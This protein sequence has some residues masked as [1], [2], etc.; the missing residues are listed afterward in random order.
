MIKYTEL[1]EINEPMAKEIKEHGWCVFTEC[2]GDG[3]YFRKGY[4]WVNRIGYVVFEEQVDVSDMDE[5]DFHQTGIYDQDFANE[6]MKVAEKYKNTN[7]HYHVKGKLI[8]DYECIRTYSDDKAK[9]LIREKVKYMKRIDPSVR[10]Y[11]F[12]EAGDKKFWKKYRTIK[13]NYLALCGVRTYP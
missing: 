5:S 7:Y 12:G 6:V 9:E 3:L 4:A 1:D 13:Q 8:D 2:D 10:A 11:R